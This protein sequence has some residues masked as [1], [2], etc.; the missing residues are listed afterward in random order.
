MPS[1]KV[2]IYIAADKLVTEELLRGRTGEYPNCLEDNLIIHKAV[3]RSVPI[4]IIID[5]RSYGLLSGPTSSSHLLFFGLYQNTD[6][7]RKKGELL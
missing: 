4:S 1:K 5:N 6:F 2:Y 3:C 7:R